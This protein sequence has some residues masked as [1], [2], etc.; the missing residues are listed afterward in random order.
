MA[1]AALSVR[2]LYRAALRGHTLGNRK[3]A[4]CTADT[5]TIELVCPR[6]RSFQLLLGVPE[7]RGRTLSPPPFR[8]EVV[9]EQRGQEVRRFAIHTSTA[10]PSNWL[11]HERLGAYILSRNPPARLSNVLK[12]G[13][14]YR[15]TV[16]FA[17]RPPAG[18]SLWLH[19]VGAP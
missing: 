7:P 6:G 16:R 12:A 17:R 1:L 15:M 9:I 3:L 11:D 14:P 18:T 2:E 13:Q 19:W 10:A 4:D 8:G 5:L